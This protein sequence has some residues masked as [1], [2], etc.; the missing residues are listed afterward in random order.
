MTLWNNAVKKHQPPGMQYYAN[1][2]M[3]GPFSQLFGII[4]LPR[5]LF[6]D[7]DGNCLNQFV[8]NPENLTFVKR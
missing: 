2:G 7:E 3:N 5:T 1:G 6:F 4:G 8:E